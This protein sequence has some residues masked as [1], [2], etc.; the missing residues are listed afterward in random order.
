M[1]MESLPGRRE[2][3]LR[4]LDARMRLRDVRL[5]QRLKESL[6]PR[7]WETGVILLLF[8]SALGL[9][10]SLFQHYQWRAAP[11]DRWLLFWFALMILSAVLSFEFLLVKV[12][13]LRRSNDLLLRMMEEARRRQD[14]L[15]ERLKKLSAEPRPPETD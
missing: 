13:H 1:E 7:W 11:P 5:S 8:A 2:E 3:L 14:R 4:E 12:Y 9:L 6:A 10:A 15:E